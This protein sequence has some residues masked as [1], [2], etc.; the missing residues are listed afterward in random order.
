M[1]HAYTQPGIHWTRWTY[2]CITNLPRT[3]QMWQRTQ[4]DSQN[5]TTDPTKL[6]FISKHQPP[7]ISNLGQKLHQELSQIAVILKRGGCSGSALLFQNARRHHTSNPLWMFGQ[8][9]PELRNRL[10]HARKIS[11][12]VA[13]GSVRIVFASPSSIKCR[14]RP[15]HA[16]RIHPKS[17]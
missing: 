13:S 12:W 14:S 3:K 6:T 5:T 15:L 9:S 8:S 4:Q 16:R 11:C 10:N 1:K 17:S 7:S 2:S